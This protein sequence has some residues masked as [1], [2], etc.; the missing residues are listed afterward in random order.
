ME[1]DAK[2]KASSYNT[3]EREIH[4]KIRMY[5][6]FL[7]RNIHILQN[8][9]YSLLQLAWNCLPSSDIYHQAGIHHFSFK[10]K[11]WTS[12]IFTDKQITVYGQQQFLVKLENKSEEQCCL[13]IP[14][15]GC[16]ECEMATNWDYSKVAALKFMKKRHTE[17]SFFCLYC[18]NWIPVT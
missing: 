11:L 3:E 7:L 14:V 1:H 9:A 16:E 17:I 4:N 5:H 15:I 18:Y 12:F 10:I 6:N 13:T 8:D 2:N